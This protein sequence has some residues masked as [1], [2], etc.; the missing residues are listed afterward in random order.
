VTVLGGCR[1]GGT[2]CLRGADHEDGPP[3]LSIIFSS[4]TARRGS[5]LKV[6]Y[7][8]APVGRGVGVRPIAAREQ[9]RFSKEFS[10]LA[11]AGAPGFEPGDGGIKIRRLSLIN[12]RTFQ[13][14]GGIL[15]LLHQGLRYNFEMPPAFHSLPPFADG[16][17]SCPSHNL[18]NDLPIKAADLAEPVQPAS[19]RRDAVAVRSERDHPARGHARRRLRMTPQDARRMGLATCATRRTGTALV[20]P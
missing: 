3:K 4:S 8:F 2:A 15:P 6:D 19:I 16:P 13:K 18:Y 5:A 1:T 12:Q 17:L 9:S 7:G 11:L 14:T 10:A 20:G